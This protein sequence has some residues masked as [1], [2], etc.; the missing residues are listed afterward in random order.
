MNVPGS[1]MA[2][3]KGNQLLFHG[4]T[5]CRNSVIKPKSDKDE[6]RL[7]GKN[8]LSFGGSS[9]AKSESVITC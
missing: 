5:D 4:V 1:A 9:G 7:G 8:T 2:S 3:T 6:L